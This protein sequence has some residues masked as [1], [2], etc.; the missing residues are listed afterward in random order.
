MPEIIGRA[1]CR[2]KD[3]FQ[4]LSR[5]WNTVAG[6]SF[7][8][9]A[10]ATLGTADSGHT[11]QEYVGTAYVISEG[12]ARL[13]FTG[14]AGSN[15]GPADVFHGDAD[16]TARVYWTK[17]ATTARVGLC[18]RSLG[19]GSF[20]CFV[21]ETGTTWRVQSVTA[22]GAVTTIASNTAG[23]SVTTGDRYELKVVTSGNSITGYVDGTS[24]IS[25]SSATNNT[26]QRH[27][28]FAFDGAGHLFDNF[29]CLRN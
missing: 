21:W 18:F 13:E 8:R 5:R 22:G 1:R 17:G 23:P 4:R 25:T 9:V 26:S 16:V 20:L 19:D 24:V 2:Q 6:D 7:Q 12:K 10:E 15:Q 14:A 28:I 11:W 29:R 27:G 3:Q